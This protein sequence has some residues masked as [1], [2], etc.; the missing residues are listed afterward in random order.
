MASTP[1]PATPPSA[2]PTTQPT[3][4]PAAAPS[5]P[6]AEPE[7]GPPPAQLTLLAVNGSTVQG[8]QYFSVFPPPLNATP[9]QPQTII[10]AVSTATDNVTQPLA[11][12]KWPAPP[13]MS[14]FALSA[15]EAISAASPTV[16]TPGS[17]VAINWK[18]G[19]FQ[20]AVTPGSGNTI[21]LVFDPAI[22]P[23]S[24]VGLVVGPGSTLMPITGEGLTLTPTLTPTYSVQFGTPWRGGPVDF[25]DV[26]PKALVSFKGN[27]AKVVI[28]SDNLIVQDDAS[29]DPPDA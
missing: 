11:T 7:A 27:T 17:T 28:G 21:K 8:I 2:Q 18:D 9:D 24:R 16:V 20:T 4:Q 29:I 5:T 19:A 1:P 22:P 25:K 14:L 15:D 12:L 13:T 6:A 23:G 3:A 10:P 26:S